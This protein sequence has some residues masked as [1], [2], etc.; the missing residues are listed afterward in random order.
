MHI[1]EYVFKKKNIFY[2]LLVAIVLG[3]IYSYQKLS[4]LED[5]EIAVMMAN[6]VTVYPGASAHQVEMEVTNVLE[7]EISALADINKIKSRSEANVSV[8]Q[9]ELEMD[10]PQDDIPQR[11]EFLRRK[12]ELAI[13]KLPEGVQKPIV[14]DDMGDVYMMFYAMVADDG[15]SYQ[16]MSD[17]ANFIR[18]NMLEVEGVRKITV[19]GE[20]SPEIHITLSPDKMSEMGVMPLQIFSALSDH[21]KVL[22]AGSL[23]SG[24]KQL[25]VN[26][27]GQATTVD[28]IRDILITAIGGS[29]FK[30]GDIATVEMAYNEPLRNTFFVNN[31]KALGIGISMESGDNILNVGKRV[32]KKLSSL[33]HQIPAGI[34]FEKVFF[35][36]E[37]V[38]DAITGFMWNLVISVLIVIVVLM[39][40]MGFRGGVIIGSG[41]VLTILATFPLLMLADGTMQRISLG[42]FIVAMG[43]LVDNAIVVLD[44]ILKEKD[45]G[46]K[47][48]TAYTKSAKQ[49][50]IPL[51]GATIIAIAAFFPVYLSPDA[52]GTY[53]RD[54]FVVLAISL[55]VSWVLALTQVPLFSAILLKNSNK[56]KGRK[57]VNFYDKPI[58]RRLTR[59]LEWGMHHRI[60]V[61]ASTFVLLFITVLMIGRVDQTF[62]P[63][64]NYNQCYIEYTLPRGSNADQV[65]EDLKEISD[66]FN[67]LDEVEMVVSSH[68]M[69]PM[70]YS[71]VRPMMTENADNYGELIVNFSDFETMIKMRPVLAQYLRTSYPEA[72]SRIRKY[73]ISILSSHTVEAE[74]TG[75][76]PAVLKH[77]SDQAQQYMLQ[78]PNV[79]KYTVSSDWEP[80]AK[81]LTAIYNPLSANKAM[82][83]RNDISN[84]ILAATDGLPIT[85]VYQGET[86]LQVRL[87]LRESDGSRIEDLNDIPVWGALPNIHGIMDNTTLQKIS[88]GALSA[89]EMIKTAITAVPLSTI[90][91][92]VEIDWEEPVVRRVNGKRVIQAQCD[93]VDG[94]GPAQV[95]AELDEAIRNINMPPGY[96]FKWV[97][98]SEM[99]VD[100]LKG[101]LSYLPLAGGIILLVLLLLFNDYRRPLIIVLCLPLS[102]IGIVPGLLLTGQPFSFV[103]IVG[104]IGLSGMII[105]NAIVL[106]DEI[107]LR[108]KES[109]T[110]Y[111]AVVDATISRVRPVIMASLTTILGML[112]LLTD[113]MYQAMAVTIISGLLVGTLITLVFVPLLYSV[114]YR[115][116]INS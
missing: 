109:P 31:Q 59:V 36:P 32:E 21:T 108:L 52:A 103:G 60:F 92:G 34:T 33:R 83:T 18:K 13:P 98:E 42:A 66:Y 51:L 50:A 55:S 97:G 62:F 49:T 5:P 95:Q 14:M 72:M 16:E 37:K 22:Y 11:W 54:L 10:V 29:S 75:P 68:G 2:F 115:V 87:M 84:A 1:S 67:S 57:A 85:K 89:N 77:L 9:I 4:K 23:Q 47:G 73:S 91:H 113:P 48:K 3:G 45:K 112:P 86:P 20:Q 110:A 107:Q 41:L 78:N 25:R 74:F 101:I 69:S 88:T 93:A 81:S 76:D 61:V 99:K 79:D 38:D 27:D 46:C 35:Q 105:K 71:L 8:I 12:L 70:R 44:G 28:D 7:N 63:D 39:F 106:L 53:I 58:Y 26:V 17:Y 56:K 104:L 65:N 24:T 94:V 82:I 15:F 116:K 30:L 90:T 80:K 64:F 40:T 43:M 111:R 102:I 96:S 100:A 19:Y 6:V 114:F